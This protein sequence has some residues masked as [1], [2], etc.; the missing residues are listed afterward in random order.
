MKKLLFILL[1]IPVWV[2]AQNDNIRVETLKLTDFMYND[3]SGNVDTLIAV[4]PD[5][6][7]QFLIMN[8]SD[9]ESA[10]DAVNYRTLQ[11]YGDS[12]GIDSM[13]FNS[14]N[15]I[16][17][18][19]VGANIIA[20][21]TLDD[22][23]VELSDSI[24]QWVTISQLVDSLDYL[25]SVITADL[26]ADVYEIELPIAGT[27]SGSI[28]AAVE[29]TDY[30]TGWNLSA[31]GGNLEIGHNLSR[32]VANVTVFYNTSGTAYRQLVNFQTAYNN[33][34]NYSNDS[35]SVVSISEY[36]SQYKLKVY[37]LFK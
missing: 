16:L 14:G 6:T 20:S 10:L 7:D 36:Y 37:L 1:F 23:Y 8:V 32:Y 12:G 29:G 21:D 34:H 35:L 31:S 3:A 9:P 30:P 5:S 4:N 13:V 28:I 2:F 11:E 33:I 26:A 15:G 24:T 22:R 17:R 18:I 19:Y 25:D 27:L